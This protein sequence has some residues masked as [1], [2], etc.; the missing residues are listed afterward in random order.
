MKNNISLI[1]TLLTITTIQAQNL[2]SNGNFE[3]GMTAWFGNA[4]N[5]QTDGDNS[6]NFANIESVG[7]SF[8]VNLSQSI[9]IIEGDTYIL[10]FQALSDRKRTIDAGIGLNEAPF[11]ENV[12]TINL[13]TEWQTYELTFTA[14]FGLPNSRVLFNMGAEIGVVLIDNV[15]LSSSTLNT[16]E[17]IEEIWSIYP[18]PTTDYLNIKIDVNNDNSNMLLLIVEATGKVVF[19]KPIV[20]LSNNQL[21]V[22]RLDNG[23]YF[24]VVYDSIYKRKLYDSKF[25]KN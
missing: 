14:T 9:E 7:N 18:N 13:T 20:S 3:D 4:F 6:F 22:R 17:F 21:D 16:E 15:S 19:R 2:I 12:E 1:I 23:L 24:L 10:T 25:I 5:V 11:T 8:D